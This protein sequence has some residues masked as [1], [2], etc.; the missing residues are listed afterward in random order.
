MYP[1]GIESQ[2]H[3]ETVIN[4]QR[5]AVWSQGSLETCPQGVEVAGTEVFLTQLNS[6][7]TPLGCGCDNLLESTPSSLMTVRDDIEAKIDMG[8]RR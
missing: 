1:R 4:Q 8:W 5:H 2:S 7:S 3:I 6:P